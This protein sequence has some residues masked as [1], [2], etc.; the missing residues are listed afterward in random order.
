VADS[1]DYDG[2]QRVPRQAVPRAALIAIGLGGVT[3]A[4]CG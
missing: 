1:G 2:G 4:A 3:V